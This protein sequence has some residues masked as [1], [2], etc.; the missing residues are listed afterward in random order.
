MEEKQ[1]FLY[2]VD[3]HEGPYSID[4]LKNIL[5]QGEARTSSYVWKE[6]LEDW[7]MLSDVPEFSSDNTS[8]EGHGK[9]SFIVKESVVTVGDVKPT[10]V[11]FCL[12]SKNTFSGPHSIKTLV[13]KLD[14]KEIS[15]QDQIWKEG[16]NKFFV[17]ADVQEIMTQVRA[18]PPK[19]SFLSK[20]FSKKKAQSGILGVGNNSVPT[21]R[22]WK[23]K[24]FLLLFFVFIPFGVYQGIAKKLIPGVEMEL[25]PIPLDGITDAAISFGANLPDKIAPLIEQNA[26]SLPT[27]VVEWFSPIPAFEGFNAEK[28]QEFRA[29]AR[30]P[31]D[32]GIQ[33]K[34]GVPAGDEINPIF[35]VVTNLPEGTSLQL[36]IIGKRGTLINAPSYR[37]KSLVEIQKFYGK[38][39]KFAHELTKPIP[40]GEYIVLIYENDKQSPEVAQLLAPLPSKKIEL[41]Q[42]SLA[43]KKIFIMENVFLGGKR[44]AIYTSRLAEYNKKAQE[45]IQAELSE[46]SQVVMLLISNLDEDEKK[47]ASVAGI[48][49]AQQKTNLWKQYSTRMNDLGTQLHTKMNKD[50]EVLQKEYI[51]ADRYI[52]LLD[53]LNQWQ[54]L[55]GA[56]TGLVENKATLTKEKIKENS[57]LLLNKLQELKQNIEKETAAVSPTSSGVT[58]NGSAQTQ[59]QTQKAQ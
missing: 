33:I 2:V 10:D 29:T 45:K 49:N 25:T 5:K 7:V 4:E 43:G 14:D 26:E 18:A 6:G 41:E 48:T 58:P 31:L 16:W 12:K 3:H 40:R 34:F 51:Y 50:K 46:L 59:Q 21:L 17:L 54:Q 57:T 24:V 52:N 13:R 19:P 44:D 22:I 35:Y 30:T 1:W 15:A 9:P 23:S 11:V 20:I 37:K 56:Y 53:Y 42:V 39:I 32:S 28:M 47:Y 55:H 38:S 8:G 27:F 36:E